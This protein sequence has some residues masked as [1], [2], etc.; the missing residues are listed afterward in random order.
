MDRSAPPLVMT[1]RFPP[2]SQTKSRPWG[3]IAIAVGRS[4]PVAMIDS[5]KLAG[6]VAPEADDAASMFQTTGY[7]IRSLLA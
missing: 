3:A 1:R 5:V 7:F 4:S 6:S 2:G